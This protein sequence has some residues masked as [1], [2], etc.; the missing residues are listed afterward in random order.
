MVS[1]PHLPG[2]MARLTIEP[3]ARAYRERRRSR[4]IRADMIAKI[5]GRRPVGDCVLVEVL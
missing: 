5:P 1:K 2:A 4:L 3:M